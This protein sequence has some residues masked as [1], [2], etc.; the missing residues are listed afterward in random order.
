MPGEILEKARAHAG[1]PRGPVGSWGG[2]GSAGPDG[3]IAADPRRLGLWLFLGTVTML[4]VGFTSAYLVRR[5]SADWRPLAIPA[6]LWW[7][8]AAIVASSGALEVARRRLRGWAPVGAVP[9]VF[10]TGILGVLFAVGQV[11]AWR[12]LAARGFYLETSPHNSFFYVLTGTHLVHLAG[13]LV[14][15]GVVLSRVRRLAYVPGEDGLGLF[16]TYWH[17][18]AGLWLYLLVLLFVV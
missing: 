6:L 17:F 12:A 4:F 2:G 5:A 15:F 16:A 7:N 10:A 1:G 8:T 11:L 14:W 3:G 9:W 18:L 13:G